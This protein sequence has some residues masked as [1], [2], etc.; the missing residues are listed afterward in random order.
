MLCARGSKNNRTLTVVAGNLVSH[1]L[2]AIRNV[3]LWC[4]KCLRKIDLKKKK[5]ERKI[6]F[7]CYKAHIF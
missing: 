2:I 7:I 5:R 3:L 4:S 6:D 1:R